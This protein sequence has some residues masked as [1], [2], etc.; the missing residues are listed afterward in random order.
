MEK[1]Q[2]IYLVY[3]VSGEFEDYMKILLKAFFSKEKAEKFVIE[4]EKGLKKDMEQYKKYCS[5][6]SGNGNFI[7]D[8]CDKYKSGEDDYCVSCITYYDIYDV[9]YIL[10]EIEVE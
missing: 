5:K 9:S 10:E 4:K 8:G 7:P 6:C 1:K 3:E 2:K